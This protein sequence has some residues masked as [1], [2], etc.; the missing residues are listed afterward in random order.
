MFQIYVFFALNSSHFVSEYF[1]LNKMSLNLL[2]SVAMFTHFDFNPTNSSIIFLSDSS[3]ILSIT[4]LLARLKIF[5]IVTEIKQMF[6]LKIFFL[7][8]LLILFHE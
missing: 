4:F 7:K 2:N 8:H 5:W 1:F 3:F 6:V